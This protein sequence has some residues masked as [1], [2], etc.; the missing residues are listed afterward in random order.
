ML[1]SR[2][3][4]INRHNLD[5]YFEIKISSLKGALGGMYGILP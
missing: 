2:Y 1:P 3:A 5:L 4:T